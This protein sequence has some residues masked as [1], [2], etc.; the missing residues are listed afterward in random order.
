M[1]VKL[2]SIYLTVILMITPLFSFY[3]QYRDTVHETDLQYE[4]TFSY[5]SD[6]TYLTSVSELRDSN[7]VIYG[8][9]YLQFKQYDESFNVINEKRY[10]DSS[11]FTVGHRSLTFYEDAYYLPNTDLSYVND[12]F[13]SSIIKFD[14]IGN[15][16]WK[17]KY[18]EN[19]YKSATYQVIEQNANLYIYGWRMLNDGDPLEVFILEADTSGMILQ[20]KI[21]SSLNESPIL[22]SKSLDGGFL[23]SNDFVNVSQYDTK[24]YKL[25][26][27]LDIEWTRIISSSSSGTIVSAKEAPDGSIFFMGTSKHPMNST[28]RSYIGK[29]SSNGNILKDSIYNFSN[30]Y[31]AFSINGNSIFK[32]DGFYIFGE[33]YDNLTSEVLKSGLYFFD[34]DLNLKWYRRYA[35]RLD[36]NSLTYLNQLDNGFISLAGFVMPDD[37]YPTTDEWFM[38]VDSM[39][40]ESME[41]VAALG[42]NNQVANKAN[43]VTLFPNPANDIISFVDNLKSFEGA[44]F[45]IYNTLGQIVNIGI[46]ENNEIKTSNLVNGYYS[47]ILFLDD[48]SYQSPLIISR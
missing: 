21:F 23:M 17:K 10:T 26:S 35:K 9:T 5:N 14:T 8:W 30:G 37:L 44:R 15:I 25:D 24:L 47:V 2:F 31:D 32:S 22:L 33:Y 4:F 13:R 20:T 18:H 12:T 40:C 36:V 29:I 16:L 6:H 42:V 41:C 45:Q 34:Y 3:G 48:K 46:I 19:Y 28:E 1:L 11:S 39:G 38:V 7:K 43:M 27:N